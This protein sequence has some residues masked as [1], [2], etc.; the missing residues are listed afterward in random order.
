[1][2]GSE[3]LKEIIHEEIKDLFNG[4]AWSCLQLY[5]VALRQQAA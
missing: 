5:A 2:E 4:L 1:M 3:G